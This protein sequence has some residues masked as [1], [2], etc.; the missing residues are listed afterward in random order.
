MLAATVTQLPPAVPPVNRVDLRELCPCCDSARPC[1]CASVGTHYACG[2]C[3]LHCPCPKCAECNKPAG[4]NSRW[5]PTCKQA[6]MDER[7]QAA[8]D[9][10]AEAGLHGWPRAD[11]E[12][13]YCGLG[14]FEDCEC[15]GRD[16][17]A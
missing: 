11:A 16:P 4:R 13:G 12:C 17:N 8:C 6:V 3:W 9:G 7:W 14:L 2:L 15:E 5:C 1:R 10:Y